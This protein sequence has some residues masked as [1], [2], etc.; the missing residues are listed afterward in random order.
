MEKLKKL[1]GMAADAAEEKVTEAV[2]LLVN[3]VKISR[4][5]GRLQGGPRGDW[6]KSRC[7]QR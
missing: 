4:N 6:R 3:K 1:L 7:R 5:R 2:E